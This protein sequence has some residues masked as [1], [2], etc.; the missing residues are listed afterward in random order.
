MDRLQTVPAEV[1]LQVEVFG[2]DRWGAA[3]A[4]DVQPD[5]ADHPACEALLLGRGERENGAIMLTDE[6]QKAAE[7]FRDSAIEYI[8]AMY[9]DDVAGT[10]HLEI[11]ESAAG[12]RIDVCGPQGGGVVGYDIY[13]RIELNAGDE[14]KAWG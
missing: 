4:V 12:C 13:D 5:E 3:F 9:G 14:W 6:Q 1:L 10:Y 2:E 8:T 11:R 7:R